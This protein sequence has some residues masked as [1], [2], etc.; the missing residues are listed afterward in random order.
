ME[1]EIQKF[2]EALDEF[3]EALRALRDAL[4]SLNK[5]EIIEA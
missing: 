3:N 4:V 1:E 2:C 5:E